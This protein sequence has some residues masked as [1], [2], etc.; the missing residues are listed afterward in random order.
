M[1]GR[2]APRYDFLNHALSLQ[3]DRLWRWRVAQRFRNILQRGDARVL[4][5]CCGTGDLTA[6][7]GRAG[8]AC[9][10]GADFA[11]PMLVRAARKG[12]SGRTE[13]RTIARELFAEADALALPFRDHSFDLL[14]AAFGLRN[15][16]N[17][18]RGLREIHRV[19]RP[20]GEVGILEFAEPRGPIFGAIYRFYFTT[21]LPGLG[22]A[23]SGDRAAYAYLPNS[24][25]RFPSPEVLAALMQRVGFVDVGFE[26][27]TGGIVTLHRARR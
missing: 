2:I 26:R 16:A 12:S 6:A 10:I 22:G 14:T 5:L 15:L 3:V 27:W 1:F 23:I 17:Y 20:G 18:E 7:L 24:V 21:I 4:D 9:I 25:A 11:H 8:R 19:L 13:N